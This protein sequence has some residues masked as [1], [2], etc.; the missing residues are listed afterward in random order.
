MSIRTAAIVIDN[1]LS[2]D[3]WSW[4]QS[5]LSDYM[6]TEEFVENVHEPY[7]TSIGWIK[8]KLSSFDFF[9]EHWNA[10]LDSWSFINTL[11]PNIDRES[12]GTGY[13]IDFGGFVYYIH[14]T[15]DESWGGN[16][17]FQNCDVDKIEPKP[18]RFV[19]IN[20]KV[21]HGIEVVNDTATHNRITIVGWPEGCI[22]YPEATQQ[23]NITY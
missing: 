9:N 1:F 10:N 5:N 13:H 15:W 3:Q 17:L 11:P 18:N 20:P 23:I 14:P 2:E 8:D 19:W 12:S 22:E 16:L 6:N 21:P 7:K 4:I